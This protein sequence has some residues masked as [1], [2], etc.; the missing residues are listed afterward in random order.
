MPTDTV[1]QFAAMPTSP[2][3]LT[4][5]NVWDAASAALFRSP[6]SP[7]LAT[8][9]AG[10][11]WALGYADGAIV[12]RADLLFAARAI[13]RVARDLPVSIDKEAGYSDDPQAVAELVV[14]LREIGAAGVNL[15]DGSREPE[16]LAAKITAVKQRLRDRGGDMFIN[17]RTDVYLRGIAKGAAAERETIARAKR[18]IAA[19]ADG[20]FAPRI[21]VN[22]IERVT[23]AFSAPLNIMADEGLPPLPELYRRGVRRISAGSAIAEL[24]F[25]KARRVVTAFM[26]EGDVDGLFSD[27]SIGYREMNQLFAAESE[28]P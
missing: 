12:P 14:A 22:A 9:N 26:R 8:T 2:Q 27:E 11:A 10:V 20:I 19:G 3:I 4:L 13:C 24:V 18:Y 6:G 23:S 1:A 21:D 25:G 16:L 15:E 17:A 5:P 28:R 7:A